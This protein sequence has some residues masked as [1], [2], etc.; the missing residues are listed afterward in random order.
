[1]EKEYRLKFKAKGLV[2][3]FPS[4]FL[5]G[6]EQFVSEGVGLPIGFLPRFELKS[7]SSSVTRALYLFASETMA[8]QKIS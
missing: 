1:M 2:G 6:E 8:M 7:I 5:V 4:L 3:I